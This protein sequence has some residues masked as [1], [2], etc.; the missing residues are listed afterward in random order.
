MDRNVEHRA[1]FGN[2]KQVMMLGSMIKYLHDHEDRCDSSC[3]EA[4]KNPFAIDNI[5]RGRFDASR[6]ELLD[7][8]PRH[9]PESLGRSLINSRMPTVI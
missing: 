9:M 2:P 1:Q 5:V 6:H 7:E 8:F 3:R 4:D